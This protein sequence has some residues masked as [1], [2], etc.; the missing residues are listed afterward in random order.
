[1]A[2]R[3]VITFFYPERFHLYRFLP[4]LNLLLI[5]PITCILQLL[6]T[7]NTLTKPNGLYAPG[8]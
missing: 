2:N 3:E 7:D 5:I 1:M 4:F 6:S 8:F